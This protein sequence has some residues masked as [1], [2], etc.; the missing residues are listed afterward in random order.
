MMKNASSVIS[1]DIIFVS[2][3]LEKPLLVINYTKPDA[4]VPNVQIL[5]LLQLN[6]RNSRQVGRKTF[7]IDCLCGKRNLQ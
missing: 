5:F 2:F 7:E 4:S 3:F 1:Y 6:G